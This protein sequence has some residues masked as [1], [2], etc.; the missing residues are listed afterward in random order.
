M[1]KVD[2]WRHPFASDSIWKMPLHVDAVYVPANIP[3]G[4]AE[5]RRAI[6]DQNIYIRCTDSPDV[7]I[8]DT[9]ITFGAG[10]DGAARCSGWEAGTL[11]DSA[12][13][14]PGFKTVSN[15]IRD[16]AGG[17]NV[18][19]VLS[20]DSD[21]LHQFHLFEACDDGPPR[22]YVSGNYNVAHQLPMTGDG[23][24]GG[25]GGSGLSV[26][27]AIRLFE[28]EE[29]VEIE[30]VLQMNPWGVTTLAYDPAS[31]T[32][33]YRWPA[34][35][36]DAY[37]GDATTGRH[38]QGL[39]PEC[40]MGSL[41]ALLPT[42]DE[43][44]ITNEFLRRVA[45]AL[46]RFGGYFVDDADR[47]VFSWN[48]AWEVQQNGADQ[49]CLE[50]FEE[51]HGFPF[52]TETNTAFL[53]QARLIISSLHV[54]D[55]NDAANIGGGPTGDPE[56]KRRAP[57]AFPTRK[58]TN[59]GFIGSLG[60]INE[61]S[62]DSSMPHE[63]YP[64]A[65]KGVADREL[66]GCIDRLLGYLWSDGVDQ[67]NGQ[68]FFRSLSLA[69][70]DEFERCANMVL[71]AA[72]VNR[73]FNTSNNFHTFTIQWQGLTEWP[74]SLPGYIVDIPAFAASVIEGEGQGDDTQPDAGKIYDGPNANRRQAFADLVARE[75]VI[76]TIVGQDVI[77]DP[78]SWPIFQN[79]PFVAFGRV[80]GA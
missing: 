61:T 47:D 64:G 10:V 8:H 40:V 37:A 66:Q 34:I 2:A 68:F 15:P 26:G 32:P 18:A 73:G 59:F 5:F 19:G 17:N 4:A 56:S 77:S 39:V 12:P 23:R 57:F 20:A 42:F 62:D 58:D 48:M 43:T 3:V 52:T 54:V 74:D 67:T 76:T 70:A 45:R 21:T 38:Y 51:I 72:N 16:G 13:I 78:V 80:P 24:L 6:S 27:G 36:S 9:D 35:R 11:W 71:G 79:W 25:H 14:E 60:I 7:D 29:G 1:P 31:P 30:H 53:D 65:K 41:M 69:I 55:S 33:G 28:M 49:H 63:I 22:T 46:K 44:L 50:R 75:N